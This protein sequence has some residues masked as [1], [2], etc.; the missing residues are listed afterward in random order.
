[1]CCAL[2][3]CVNHETSVREP[4]R[5]VDCEGEQRYDAAGGGELQELTEGFQ[6]AQGA[7]YGGRRQRGVGGGGG[8]D[9]GVAFVGVELGGRFR[10]GGA[11]NDEMGES[12]KGGRGRGEGGCGRGVAEE[13]AR[14][15]G[16]GGDGGEGECEIGME[17]AD[18]GA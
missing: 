6:A 5:I 7:V 10:G 12:V 4:R 2:A 18:G 11:C 17:G 14:E 3:P 16:W 9:E 13:R 15:G 1:M 8:D